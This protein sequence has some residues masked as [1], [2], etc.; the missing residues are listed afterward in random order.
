MLRRIFL[1]VM[2]W[3]LAAGFVAPGEAAS[4]HMECVQLAV[5]T[6]SSAADCGNGGMAVGG[7]ASACHAGACVAPDPLR[8]GAAPDYSSA[9]D[10]PAH[11]FVRSGTM[12][13]TAPPKPPLA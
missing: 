10:L 1:A 13:E 2:V 7:C 12:P 5:L 11:R 3:A 8:F 9:L 6:D 4:S